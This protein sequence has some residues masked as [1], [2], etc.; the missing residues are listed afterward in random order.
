MASRPRTMRPRR[1]VRP[2]AATVLGPSHPI[3][4]A[5]AWRSAL[6]GQLVANTVLLL[7][8]AVLSRGSTGWRVVLSVGLIVELLLACGLA[9]ATTLLRE[10]TRNAIADGG[11]KG[12][13]AEV[14][15]VA[16]EAARLGAPRVRARLS[17]TLAAALRDA[18]RWPTLSVNSRPPPAVQNLLDHDAVVREIIRLAREPKAPVRALALLDRMLREGYSGMVYAGPSDALGRELGRV[19]YLL[20]EA[21][22]A[23]PHHEPPTR[24]C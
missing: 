1:Q 23:A 22:D 15:E 19:R 20:A 7:I 11:D 24:G 18:E 3:A 13:L 4:R 8:A 21:P 16:A 9:L 17:D 14:R 10:R 12:E 5:A 6:G 2:A